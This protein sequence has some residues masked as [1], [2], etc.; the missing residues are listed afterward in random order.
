M[1]MLAELDIS[2]VLDT[3]VLV[4]AHQQGSDPYGES[5]LLISF[6]NDD[7]QRFAVTPQ[8]LLEFYSIVTDSRRVSTPLTSSEATESIN[9]LLALPGIFLLPHPADLIDRLQALLEKHP[10]T[11]PEIY[12]LQIVA[13]MLAYDVNRIYTYDKG[14]NRFDEIKAELPWDT[15]DKKTP[16]SMPGVHD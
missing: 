15:Q 9:E 2:G 13:T 6:A 8:I 5:F 11:G 10:V 14:F 12:D 16:D 1:A 7:R 4:Y 3:N